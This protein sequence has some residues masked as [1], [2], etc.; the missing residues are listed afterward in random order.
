VIG[1]G[2]QLNAFSICEFY[3]INYRHIVFSPNWIPSGDHSPPMITKQYAVAFINKLLWKIFK[4]FLNRCI[5]GRV[6]QQRR[7]YHLPLIT[8]VYGH[9]LR[10]VIVSHSKIISPLEKSACQI[11]ELAYPIF[12]SK[13]TLSAKVV[14]FVNAGPAPI[15]IG[16]GSMPNRDSSAT[17]EVLVDVILALKLRAVIQRGWAGF[18]LNRVCENVVFVDEEPHLELF[19]FMQIIIHHGGA[20]TTYSAVRSGRPQ[21]IIPHL[22]DQFYWAHRMRKLGVAP[23][24]IPADALTSR[25]L[26][27][28]IVQVL[29]NS[30]YQKNAREIATKIKTSKDESLCAEQLKTLINNLS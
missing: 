23:L 27:K 5:R 19:P 13:R 9:L 3:K 12:A 6:N 4:Y 22:L 14:R 10:N 26:Q 15:F 18:R 30:F 7:L 28:R 16:F 29:N 17:F 1:T 2:L 20:G 25:R 24:A 8:D 21:I 11:S